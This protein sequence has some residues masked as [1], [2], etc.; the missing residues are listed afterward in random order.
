MREPAGVAPPR[1]RRGCG[2]RGGSGRRWARPSAA[3]RAR[4]LPAASSGVGRDRSCAGCARPRGAR[5]TAAWP[6]PPSSMRASSFAVRGRTRGGSLGLSILK[7]RAL[8][9]FDE[10]DRRRR[11]ARRRARAVDEDRHE[12]GRSTV[13]SPC[14]RRVEVEI[15]L[16][17]RAR[18]RGGACPPRRRRPPSRISAFAAAAV[19]VIARRRSRRAPATPSS[20]CSSP[21]ACISLTMSQPPTNSPVHVELRDGRPARELLDALAHR[22]VGEDVHG[23]VVRPDARRGSRRPRPRSRTAG[24]WRLPFMKRTT[25]LRGDEALDLAA[26]GLGEGHGG[27][28]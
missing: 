8:R 23:L 14:L 22:R 15:V 12:P 24:S 10:V 9:P 21:D 2:C 18:P 26:D 6:R 16:E 4:A 3:L 17:A 7:P 27:M 20:F 11:L 5:R 13:R 19:T 28:M 1:P 25:G